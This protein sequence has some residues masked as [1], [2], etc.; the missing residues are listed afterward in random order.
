MKQ[1]YNECLNRV[2][3]PSEADRLRAEIAKLTVRDMAERI[4]LLE[5]QREA[6]AE[7]LTRA[8]TI[9]RRKN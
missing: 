3:A 8:L 4:E 9:L 6:A 2:E 5:T 7:Y 1:P